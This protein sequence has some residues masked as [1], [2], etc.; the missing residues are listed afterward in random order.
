MGLGKSCSTGIV[1]G[2]GR[3]MRAAD[4]V[5]SGRA[6]RG[7]RAGLFAGRARGQTGREIGCCYEWL[8]LQLKDLGPKANRFI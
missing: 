4:A 7:F 5:A 6:G 3:R 8:W 2:G 1:G